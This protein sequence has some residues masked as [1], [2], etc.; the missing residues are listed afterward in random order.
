MQRVRAGRARVNRKAGRIGSE[1][2]GAGYGWAGQGRR[3]VSG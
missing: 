2:G 1:K 3:E